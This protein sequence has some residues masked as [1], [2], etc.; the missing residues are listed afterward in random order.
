MRAVDNVVGNTE[1]ASLVFKKM[2][3]FFLHG[4]ATKDAAYSKQLQFLLKEELTR[5]DQPL[6]H[7]YPGFWGAVLKQTGQIWNWIHQDLQNFKHSFPQIDVREVFRY[8]EFREDFISQFFGDALTYFNTYRGEHIRDELA[9]QL[10]QFLKHHPDERELHLVTHSLGS[11]ILW[12]VLFSERFACD[13]PAY[14]IR[15]LL[16]PSLN[17][18]NDAKIRLASITTMGSPILFFNLMLDIQ[19]E[20][21]KALAENYQQEPLRWLNIIHSSDIIAYPLQASLDAKSMSNIFF[22]DKY[23][24]ADANGVEQLARTFGQAHA[25]MAVAVSDAHSSYWHSRGVARLIAAN[26]LG[27]YTI[28]DSG[29]IDTQ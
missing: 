29:M 9:N 1:G 2:L 16:T 17:S 5:R 19:P 21:L 12:D 15:S 28:V 22:R 7:Y 24:W 4:V 8:Q 26:L 11:V 25:A 6:P 14:I 13:D 20:K 23:I 27:D 3:V 18:S 10:Y